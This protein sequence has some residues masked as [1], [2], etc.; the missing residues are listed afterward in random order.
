MVFN[1]LHASWYLTAVLSRTM[2]YHKVRYRG[3]VNRGQRSTL[4]YIYYILQY[5]PQSVNAIWHF[6]NLDIV[7]MSIAGRYL[8]HGYN[9][10]P[11]PLSLVISWYGLQ[12]ITSTL[13][14][15]AQLVPPLVNSDLLLSDVISVLHNPMHSRCMPFHLMVTRRFVFSVTADDGLIKQLLS[16]EDSR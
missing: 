9:C 10:N 12:F 16:A 5:I 15:V 13:M 6:L 14:C 11:K 4:Y 7:S 3:G 1:V 8:C 2:H